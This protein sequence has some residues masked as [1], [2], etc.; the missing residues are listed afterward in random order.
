MA[1][2]RR[3]PRCMTKLDVYG[4]EVSH[5]ATPDDVIEEIPMM[6]ACPRCGWSAALKEAE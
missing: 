4:V 6:L 2:K 3:C 1:K 5:V